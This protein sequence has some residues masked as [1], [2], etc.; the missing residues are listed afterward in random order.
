MIKCRRCTASKSDVKLKVEL[1][2]AA[3]EQCSNLYRSHRV[4]L[5]QNQICAGGERDKDSC[6]G[7][8]WKIN[9]E[10]FSN[11]TFRQLGDSGGPLMAV[12]DSDRLVPYRYY[13]IVGIVSFGLDCGQQGWPG[14]Y[15]KVD[16]YIDWILSHMRQ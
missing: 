5:T 8:C 15:T 16:R 12:D 7:K 2:G 4:I 1:K 3:W 10:S 14:V 9:F 13:Y 11:A 6:Q